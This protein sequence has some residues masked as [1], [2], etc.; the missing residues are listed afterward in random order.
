MITY[1][2]HDRAATITIN[3]P[4][5]RNPFSNETA[6]DLERYIVR[7]ATDDDVSV[8]VI[9]G[10]GEKAFSAGGDLSGGFVDNPLGDHEGRAAL[11]DVFRAMRR[12]PKPIVGRVNGVALGGGFGVAVACDITIA[13]DDAGFGTPEINLG[14]WPMLISAV[15]VR[16]M[17]RKALLDMMLTGRVIDANEAF[18]LGLVTRVVPRSDL[19]GAVA[20]VV[21]SLQSQSPA[22]LALGKQAFYAMTDMDM[23]TALDHLHN[24]LTA[25]AMT[26]DAREGVA[27]FLDR[28][29]PTWSGR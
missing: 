28:R 29:D 21:S 22:A 7:S 27:A 18:E 1:E 17:P 12:N 4:E 16:V 11:A 23:D 5:R 9:T 2:I 20:S 25:T 15:L 19:D 13:T 14:L 10:A 26:Q 3:D 6:R 24:G 8:V